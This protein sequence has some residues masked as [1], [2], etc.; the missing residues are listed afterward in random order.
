[1]SMNTKDR[2]PDRRRKLEIKVVSELYNMK[3]DTKDVDLVTDFATNLAT[4]F[5]EDLARE[6]DEQVD[7]PMEEP[8]PGYSIILLTSS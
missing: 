8:N 7:Y 1:M 3:V 5:V 2:S 6:V 4:D